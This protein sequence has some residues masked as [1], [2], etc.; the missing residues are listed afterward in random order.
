MFAFIIQQI[1]TLSKN[2]SRVSG[3]IP[4]EIIVNYS[5]G[6]AGFTSHPTALTPV[7]SAILESQDFNLRVERG[8]KI[9]IHEVNISK[10]DR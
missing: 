1:L 9:L 8:Q 5:R 4:R 10:T 6:I 3:D 7:Q 2:L